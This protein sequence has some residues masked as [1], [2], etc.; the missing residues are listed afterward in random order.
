MA[1]AAS[2][3]A[4]PAAAMPGPVVPPYTAEDEA[5]LADGIGCYL[6]EQCE[7]PKKALKHSTWLSVMNHLRRGHGIKY[8]Q[9][10]GSYLYEK[11][12][13]EKNAKDRATY[14]KKKDTAQK[15]AEVNTDAKASAVKEGFLDGDVTAAEPSE[16]GTWELVWL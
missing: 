10:T 14:E 2:S 3:G 7:N 8:S 15:T 13:E 9:I 1:S 5:K 11:A 6:C 16:E 12:K 4:A